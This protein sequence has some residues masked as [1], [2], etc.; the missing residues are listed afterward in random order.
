MDDRPAYYEFFAGGGMARAGL[1]DGWRCLFAND[2]DRKKAESYRANWGGEALHVGDVRELSTAQLPGRA[3]LVWASFPCQDLSLAGAGAGLAGERSGTFWPFWALMK[4]LRQEGR[5]PSLIVLENVCGA[6]TS[7][8]GEDFTKICEAL[9]KERY[10]FGALVIDAALF[11]PQSRPRLFVIAAREDVA[12]PSALMRKSANAP[13]HTRALVAAHERLPKRLRDN[14]L[15]W[16]LPAPPLR[17]TALI[18]AIEDAPTDA[19]WHSVSETNALIAMMS[20]VNLAKIAEAKRAGRKMVG[21]LYRRT[22]YQHGAKVQRAEARFD[23]IA[24]CLRTPAGGS[25]RQYV[26]VVDKGRVRSRLMSARETARLM[27]LPEDYLL[28]ATYS[29]AYHLTGDGVVVPVVRHLAASLL[30]PLLN[31]C[32]VQ[33][34]A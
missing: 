29:D 10:R 16:N 33:E 1:G 22:R 20:D 28:P 8:G 27:G 17:N 34:A 2:F 11:I 7:H 9:A 4:A 14:W 24:G 23:D 18:D 32:A 5:A 12:V 15:W 31:T 19:A 21:T 30:G 25:S 3:D 6:L 26:L 13:F